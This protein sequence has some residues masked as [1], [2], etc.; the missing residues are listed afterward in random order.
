[1]SK[2]SV[3]AQSLSHV[4]LFVTL[5]NIA[6]QAPLSMGFSQQEYCSG[7]TFP[8][9][10]DLPHLG[11]KSLSPVAPPLAGRMSHL[12]TPPKTLKPTIKKIPYI[13]RRK[14]TT[15][16]WLEWHNHNKIKSYT[17]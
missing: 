5:W 14:E 4:R 12:E 11:I 6:W 17:S 2:N 3:C 9:L 16:R 13:Q 8:P 7:L 15:T 1:M 10:G